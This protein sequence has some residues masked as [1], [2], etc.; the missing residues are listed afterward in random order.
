MFYES[1]FVKCFFQYRSARNPVI[2]GWK[3]S[4]QVIIVIPTRYITILDPWYM[5]I[6]REDVY[7]PIGYLSCRAV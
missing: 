1:L 3:K 6:S 2:S 4:S 5:F 7:C